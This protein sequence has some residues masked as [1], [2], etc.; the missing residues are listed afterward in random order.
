[1]L[2]TDAVTTRPS[3]RRVAVIAPATSIN[4]MIQPPKISPD[5]LVSAGIRARI[6]VALAALVIALILVVAR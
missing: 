3:A 2:L 5:G 1:M 4:D 6:L